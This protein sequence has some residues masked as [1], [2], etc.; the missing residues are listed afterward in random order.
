MK[1]ENT[2]IVA[3]LKERIDYHRSRLEALNIALSELDAGD[4]GDTPLPRKRQRAASDGRAPSRHMHG[5]VLETL[6][7]AGKPMTNGEL[8]AAL[9]KSGYEYALRPTYMTKTLSDLKGEKA[10]KPVGPR[11]YALP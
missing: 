5:K 1:T 9:K 6:K 2:A 3:R 7:A 8:L 11:H 4:N 10:I